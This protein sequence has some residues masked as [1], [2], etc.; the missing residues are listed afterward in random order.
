MRPISEIAY[1]IDKDWG[2]KVNFAARPYLDAMYSLSNIGDKFFNDSGKSVVLYFLSNAGT[3]R[4][5]VA[6]RVKNELALMLKEKT[7]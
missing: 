5:E 4:G 7:R 3:W 2:K 1:E 6:R